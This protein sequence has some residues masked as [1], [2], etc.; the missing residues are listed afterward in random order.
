ME[1][2]RSNVKD[3]LSKVLFV[4]GL[5]LVAFGYG[6]AAMQSG[7][8]PA[9]L[10]K[11]ATATF[12]D[13]RLHWRNDLGLEPTRHLGPARHPGD[14]VTVRDEARMEPGLTWLA[15]MFDE[16]MSARLIE[17]DGTLIHSWPIRYTEIWPEVGALND[18]TP[19][20]D[21]NVFVHG[22]LALPDGSIVFTFDTG[23]S[24][25]K[26]DACGD[27]V[28][29]SKRMFHHS[30]DR[31]EDGTYW[32]PLA[33]HV[34]QVAEGG[35]T[36]QQ[37]WFP[38]VVRDAEQY[39]VYFIQQPQR[40]DGHANDV[41]VLSEALAPAF[42]LFEAGDVL[43]SLRD[44]N[45]VLVFDPV[46]KRI[47]WYQHGPWLRQHDPDFMADGRISIF[48]NRTTYDA[49]R[50]VAID[51]V[52]RATETLYEGTPEHPFYSAIRGKHQHQPNGNIL[53]TEAQA[54]RV[55]EVTPAGEIVW[56]YINRYDE[57]RVLVVA[58]AIR[59]PPDYFDFATWPDC[60]PE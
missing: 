40:T 5:M 13:L 29:K 4:L 34:A 49:S 26:M 9:K 24:L 7:W 50:I 60:P 41:E 10:I 39:G 1:G 32:L 37:I 27:V 36:L 25:V 14:G 59:Y 55:F 28:W 57:D 21:W 16:D 15:G 33:D 53:I 3:I 17:A 45:L 48:D 31:A 11:N 51:P 42:P 54:G 2:S 23:Q 44:I 47:K 20:T 58:N 43:Y 38:K 46:S 18:G 22:G 30:V 8:F 6:V 52:T 19:V 56:E 35:E 12:Q